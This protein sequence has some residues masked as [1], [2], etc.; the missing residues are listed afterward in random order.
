M[1][2]AEGPGLGS[3]NESDKIGQSDDVASVTD[4]YKKESASDEDG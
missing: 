2:D 3:T 4:S 1:Y